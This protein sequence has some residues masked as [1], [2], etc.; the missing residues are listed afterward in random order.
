MDSRAVGLGGQ[1]GGFQVPDGEVRAPGPPTPREMGKR[2]LVQSP[3]FH[4]GHVPRERV[5]QML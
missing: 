3:S 1:T 5:E 4:A 2:V